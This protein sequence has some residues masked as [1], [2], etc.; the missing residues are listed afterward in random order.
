[1]PSKHRS[2]AGHYHLVRVV[3]C[4]TR[5]QIGVNSINCTICFFGNNVNW[6]SE[7][8]ISH[9]ISCI[10]HILYDMATLEMLISIQSLVFPSE[11]HVAGKFL[12][13]WM[14]QIPFSKCFK[15]CLTACI[16]C[17]LIQITNTNLYNLESIVCPYLFWLYLQAILQKS[18]V[19][20][21]QIGKWLH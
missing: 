10:S 8:E 16:T 19:L 13:C 12:A 11:W 14:I 17:L 21:L 2:L 20:Q 5:K 1:M 3:H 7:I 18:Q 4:F 9:R 15:F 6:V